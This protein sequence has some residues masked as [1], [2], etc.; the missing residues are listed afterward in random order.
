MLVVYLLQGMIEVVYLLQG[1]I[2]VVVGIEMLAL[3]DLLPL[4]EDKQQRGE[5]LA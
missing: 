2:E 5:G 1:M 4:M 3:Y